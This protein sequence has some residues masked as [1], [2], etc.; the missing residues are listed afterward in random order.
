MIL[1][2]SPGWI[3]LTLL[4]QKLEWKGISNPASQLCTQFCFRGVLRS[5][6]CNDNLVLVILE[7]EQWDI[8]R[9]YSSLDYKKVYTSTF[10]ELETPKNL[11]P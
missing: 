4:T 5:L 10:E 8:D 11:L 2:S 1:S 6:Q 9:K 3:P 7:K